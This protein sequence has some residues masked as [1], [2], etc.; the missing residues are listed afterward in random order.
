MHLKL[1][2][3]H[4]GI[5]KKGDYYVSCAD[6]EDANGNLVDMDFF[7]LTRDGEMH[8]QSELQY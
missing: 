5:V 2:K 1:K 3:L 6:F 8:T 7:V 4:D